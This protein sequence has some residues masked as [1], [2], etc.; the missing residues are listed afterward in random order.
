MP[1]RGPQE[2]APAVL[3]GRSSPLHT[4]NDHIEGVE[5]AHN[6]GEIGI[7]INPLARITEE[8]TES[9]KRLGTVHVAQAHAADAGIVQRLGGR[10]VGAA[11]QRGFEVGQRIAL[12][13]VRM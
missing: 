4:H 5:N 13:A 9:K 6:I 2:L 10:L 11:F 1:A 8:I 3:C 7:G 12:T